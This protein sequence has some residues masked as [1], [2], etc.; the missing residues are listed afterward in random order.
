[1]GKS[2]YGKDGRNEGS[3]RA[4]SDST[5]LDSAQQ[6][7]LHCTCAKKAKMATSKKT[8]RRQ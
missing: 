1:M 4:E 7:Y 3:G 2:K 6:G 8:L 5:E